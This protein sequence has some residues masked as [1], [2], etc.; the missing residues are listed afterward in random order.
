MSRPPVR[1][2]AGLAG[3]SV[4]PGGVPRRPG[5][6]DSRLAS[7]FRE[8]AG[9]LGRDAP[10]AVVVVSDGRVRDPE[11]LNEM[12]SVWQRLRVPV[13]VVPVGRTA[14]GGDV[15]IVAAVAPAKARK[16][17]QV[18]VDVFLRSFGFAGQRAELQLQ[19]LDE[20]GSF[21]RTLT[22]LP[23]TLQDGVQP[24]CA[25]ARAGP[26]TVAVCSSRRRPAT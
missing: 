15:A 17:S 11:K 5:G 13:H 23:V 18:T 2:A 21:R 25:S 10:A 6:A 3:P 16:Q 9:R 19:A 26:E 14:E 22:T 8:L 20:K 7:A 24:T 4:A 12:A 1:R